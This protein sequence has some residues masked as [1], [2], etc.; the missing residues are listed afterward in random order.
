MK[1][2]IIPASRV[3]KEIIALLLSFAIALLIN[4]YSIIKYQTNW[5]ELFSQIG[6]VI[7]FTIIIYL[8]SVVIRLIIAGVKKTIKKANN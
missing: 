1:D 6:Y 4:V 2:I 5:A 7:T 8:L 3:K